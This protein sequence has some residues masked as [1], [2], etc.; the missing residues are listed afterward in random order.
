MVMIE[1]EVSAISVVEYDP[2][3]PEFSLSYVLDMTGDLAW[4]KDAACRDAPSELFMAGSGLAQCY[5]AKRV[6]SSCVVRKECLEYALSEN[7]ELGV[8]GG[9][10]AKERRLEGY[11]RK[12]EAKRKGK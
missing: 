2:E 6:C 3:V 1:G 12:R 7:L 11:R 4:Q 10:N 9:M 8:F 5:P